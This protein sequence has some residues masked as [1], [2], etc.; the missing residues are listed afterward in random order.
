MSKEAISS[1]IGLALCIAAIWFFYPDYLLYARNYV[2]PM[3]CALFGM[4]TFVVLKMAIS[5][6]V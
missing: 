2:V 6:K 5:K 3:W 1:S 4:V